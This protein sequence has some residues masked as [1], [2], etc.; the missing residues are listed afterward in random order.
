MVHRAFLPSLQHQLTFYC[1]LLIF[2]FYMLLAYCYMHH[3]IKYP[4]FR[5]PVVNS[6]IVLYCWLLDSKQNTISTWSLKVHSLYQVLNLHMKFIFS[7]VENIFIQLAYLEEY[8]NNLTNYSVVR[9]GCFSLM[10]L[11][12]SQC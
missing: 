12:S 7:K 9:A 1:V 11:Y 8:N 5:I 6:C 2:Y 10:H 4:L 3:F